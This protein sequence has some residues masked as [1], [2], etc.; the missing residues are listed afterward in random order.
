MAAELG[1]EGADGVRVGHVDGAGIGAVAL[2]FE[3]GDFF[4][5]LVGAAGGEDGVR[6]GGRDFLG[7]RQADTTAGAYDESGLTFEGEQGFKR[8]FGICDE[9]YF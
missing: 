4:G 5:E 7:D 6:A 1:G 9:K 3:G 2:G 8:H